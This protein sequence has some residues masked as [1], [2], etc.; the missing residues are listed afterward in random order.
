M[1]AS[2]SVARCLKRLGDFAEQYATTVTVGRTHYQSASLV[3]V[4]KRACLWAQELLMTFEMVFT[5]IQT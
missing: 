3:T 4:G 1:S 2:F 5:K